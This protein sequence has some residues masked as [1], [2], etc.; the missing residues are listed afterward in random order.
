MAPR[1]GARAA[2]TTSLL[3]LA[4]TGALVVGCAVDARGA[5]EQRAA[6][7]LETR[8]LTTACH[9]VA[10][11]EAWPSSEGFF[12]RL[13]ARGRIAALDDAREAALSR[14]SV[15]APRS[16]SLVRVPMPGWAS[17]G[18][19]AGG[20]VFVAPDDPA[21]EALLSWIALEARGGEDVDL[22]ELESVF[23]DDVLPVL[24][25]RCARDGCHG[26]SD[27]AFS[28]FGIRLDADGRT[29]PLAIRGARSAVRRHLDLVGD[30]PSRSR[31]VRKAIG[32]DEG[33]LVHRG[34]RGTFFPE[35]PPGQPLE[36]PG[37][38]AILGWARMER[39]AIG[40]VDPP[41][42]RALLWVEGPSAERAPYRITPGPTGS[43]LF[44]AGWPEL[45]DTRNL[46]SSLH[47][48]ED[49]EIRDPAI[50][51]DGSRVAFAMRRESESRFSLFEIELATGATRA[52]ALE[53]PGSLVEPT[54]APD[55]RWIA[56]WDGHGELS[57]DAD[58]VAPELVAIAADGDVERL[59]FTPAPEVSPGFLASGKTRGELVF[60]TRRDGPSGAEGLLFRFPLCHDKALHGEPE[61]HVQFGA[62][63]APWAPRQARDLPD[64]RQVIVALP[65]AAAEDDHGALAILD[66]SLGPI[67]REG[68]PSS[69]AGY[70]PAFTLLD[71]E[72]RYRDPAPL[73]D[74]R[75]IVARRDDA[76]D[77]ALVLVRI[78]DG[79]G[80]PRME[81]EPLLAPSAGSARSPVAVF[82]R[83]PED[84]DHETL[85]DR[86][87]PLG[88]FVLRDV[89]VLES[90][91]GRTEPTGERPLRADIARIRLLVPD[92][93]P[94]TAFARAAGGG[95]TVG[96]G[97]RIPTRVLAELPLAADRSL[98]LRVPARTPIRLELLD[99]DGMI[100]G[101]QLERWFYAEGEETVPGGT[102]APTYAH[103]CAGCHGSASG[104]PE[105]AATIAP[106]AVSSASVTLSTHA[107]RDR[108]RPLE[109]LLVEP[110][111]RRV[112]FV[113]T[114]A[115][116]IETRCQACHS[117][118]SPAGGLALEGR[119]SAPPFS[120]DYRALVSSIDLEGLRARQS[121]LIERITG[122]ELDAPGT[123]SGRC[124]P[125]GD[126][127]LSSA[128]VEWIEAGAFYDL[129]RTEEP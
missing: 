24:A 61:Y 11:D 94:A 122:R 16:S 118:A 70:R 36:A 62:S 14:A 65:S 123:P 69:L 34:S 128:F 52:I 49:A 15:V 31:L 111:S 119:T 88:T 41:T 50:S 63:A 56:A 75:V 5:F 109:P 116:L 129:S 112:D 35:A 124:P 23:G 117:G 48:G 30:D 18:P 77:D 67:L 8:C 55:G 105:A 110:T 76:G 32:E 28:G 96:L 115:A 44:V 9:G 89:A 91:Y 86:D 125:D 108:R 66:R 27:V 81:L 98:W 101:R 45:S 73:P 95:T 80:G 113:G 127:A 74:G 126:D 83:P 19:H 2:S 38:Q 29:S 10:P 93:R 102:N 68:A 104:A 114:I 13:D 1:P 25:E 106:D 57:A 20:E 59:T 39:A 22:T 107:A 43:D 71:A 99:T 100:I 37:I 97:E 33:G 79:P 40:I 17:G 6:P 42:A 7:V 58:G 60:G 46:T 82:S 54:H 84:D 51:H 120:D 26:P 90:L 47:P 72:P 121:P 85:T 12:V 78:I 103:A 21:A 92:A 53:M 3:L 87:A 4:S 64:G